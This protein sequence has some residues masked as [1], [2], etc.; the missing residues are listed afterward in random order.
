MRVLAVADEVDEALRADPR[1][2][3]DVDI[4]VACGDLPFDY[5]RALMDALDVPLVFVPGNHDPSVRGFRTSR[6]GLTLRAG[7]PA[8]PPWPPGA[9]NADGR[10]VDVGGLR[11]A[12]L[13]GC[14][15]YSAGPNQY[16]QGEQRRRAGRLARRATWRRRRD[17]RGVDLLL[18][19]APPR[20]VGDADDP[21]HRGFDCLARLIGRLRTPLLLHGHVHPYG[22]RPG[23]LPLGPTTVR[24]VVGR[25]VFDVPTAEDR[26][27]EPAVQVRR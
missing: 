11:I 25:H 18:T 23:D 7:L 3:G 14:P 6:A 24:N 13:G 21:P 16:T 10:V 1:R 15:R 27:G 8:T 22:D 2:A 4:V 26:L 19:H 5:L 9:V 20:G 12:G 17:G